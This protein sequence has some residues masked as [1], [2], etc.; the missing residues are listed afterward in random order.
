MGITRDHGYTKILSWYLDADSISI[1]ILKEIMFCPGPRLHS[2]GLSLLLNCYSSGEENRRCSCCGNQCN[3]LFFPDAV[4]HPSH[5][6][7]Q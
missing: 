5:D 6:L 3:P 7:L 1:V 4:H 2:S